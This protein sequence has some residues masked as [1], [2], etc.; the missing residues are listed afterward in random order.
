MVGDRVGSATGMRVGLVS[1][2]EVVFIGKLTGASVC[3]VEG[4]AIGDCIGVTGDTNGDSVAGGSFVCSVVGGVNGMSVI[5]LPGTVGDCVPVRVGSVVCIAVG[6]A[7][8]TSVG[9]VVGIAVGTAVGTNVG[10]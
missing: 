1:G 4:T 10:V 3:L 6:T 9:N 2:M 7:V 5:V 8:G